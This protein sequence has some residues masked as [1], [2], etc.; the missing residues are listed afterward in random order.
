MQPS[1]FVRFFEKHS[2]PGSM[3]RIITAWHPRSPDLNPFDFWLWGYLR[4]MIYRD[5]ITSLSDRKV[6]TERHVRNI[7]HFI[8][9]STVEHAILRFQ[10]VVDYGGQ[11]IEHVL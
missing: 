4:V 6:I 8:L 3:A 7:P 5:P 11:C 9:I 1:L 2:A 10:M